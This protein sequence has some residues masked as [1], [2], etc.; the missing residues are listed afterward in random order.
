MVFAGKLNTDL[1]AALRRAHVPGV[2]LSGVDGDLIHARRRPLL[3]VTDP[4]SGS[5]REV[6]FGWVGDVESVDPRLLVHLLE[7]GFVPAVAPL[8]AGT[9]APCSTSTPTPSPPGWRCP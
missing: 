4:D 1:L 6:D 2:G 5:T 3:E 7:G 8:P 9:T